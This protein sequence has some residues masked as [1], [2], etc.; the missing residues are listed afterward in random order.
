[1]CSSIGTNNVMGLVRTTHHYSANRSHKDTVFRD[2]F[3]TQEHKAN[4]LSLY[5]ALS[6][7]NYD[8]PDLLEFTTL[9]DV[10]Y[11]S[12][13]NDISFLIDDT[14]ILWEHQSTHNPNMPL[15]GLT[16]FAR[17]YTAWVERQDRS[18]YGHTLIELPTPRYFVF[19]VGEEDRP[20]K[21]T[22]RRLREEAI[23]EDHDEGHDE[24]YDE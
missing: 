3:G 14:M 4:T 17:L 6:G 20:D 15:R 13:K 1:M 21:E 18:I 5:N 7:K 11:M 19:F 10:L 22:M 23:R 8:D 24:G 2:L 9:D 16:Y 12:V